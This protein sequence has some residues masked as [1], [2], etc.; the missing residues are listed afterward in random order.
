[1]LLTDSEE[2]LLADLL[3]DYSEAIC[4]GKSPSLDEI[5]EGLPNDNCRQAFR[6]IAGVAK[7]IN[8][9]TELEERATRG[10]REGEACPLGCGGTLLV[11]M[12][13]YSRGL[14]ICNGGD[15]WW[16][17]HHW[18]IDHQG[19]VVGHGEDLVSR[20]VWDHRID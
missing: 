10:L 4:D 7:L 5:C 8:V 20:T 1:M 3:G 12:L 19:K 17:I 2:R 6:R 9:G 15:K 14:A 18:R 13:S 16:P 11:E